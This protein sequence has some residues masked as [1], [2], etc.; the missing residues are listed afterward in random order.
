MIEQG[1]I[2]L[3]RADKPRIFYGY[4]VVATCFVIMVIMHGIY[5][6]FGIF[7]TSLESAFGVTRAVL[8]GASSVA[9]VTMGISSIIAGIL[10]DKFGPRKVMIAGA[11]L[12]SGGFL[13]TSQAHTVWQLY[14]FIT[15]SGIG[16]SVPDIVPLS[17]VVRW[18]VKKRG[19]MS[20]I[21]KVGTG[22]G[23]TIMPIVASILIEAVG[24]RNAYLIL[25]TL[26]L[27]TVIPLTLILRRD[28]REMG[29][30]PDGEQKPPD[31]QVPPLVEE[32]LTMRLALQTS[33]F[34]LVC[35]YYFTI[36]FCSITIMTHIAPHAMDI[37]ISRTAAALIVSIIG[38]TS[39]AGRLI[40]GFS[41]D[42]IGHKRGVIVCFIILI[43]ALS[44]LQAA[45]HPWMLFLFAAIYGFCHGGFFALISPLI[46]G[47]F[48]TRSQGVL[49][50]SIIFS[51][52][53]GGGIGMV[54]S[55]H[56]F[57][58]TGNY[59][60]AFIILLA[61]AVLGLTAVSFIKLITGGEKVDPVNR[62]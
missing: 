12:F 44:L 37:G 27:V 59:D 62:K 52:T 20:G 15:L 25:G 9:F 42:R 47:L 53:I 35:G 49:L 33:Q 21:T 48:G 61:L 54:V 55:G 23:M 19:V 36:L 6:T 50:G 43:T 16:L 29:L 17:T 8:S 31:A 30:L 3:K 60:I 5:N 13:L 32:G 10:A 56:I 26:V 7:F 46:A 28:P 57:D 39:I 14:L 2:P 40:M 24:W 51:G 34:W 41:G 58:V 18:F 11:I 4:I 45:S 38:G 1:M 22:A